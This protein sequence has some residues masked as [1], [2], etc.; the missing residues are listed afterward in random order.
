MTWSRVTWYSLGFNIV[1]R[2][3]YFYYGLKGDGNAHQIFVNA[4][5]LQALADM[6]RNEGPVSFN[7]DGNYFVTN[8][9]KV[10]E[11][12]VKPLRKP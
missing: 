10:G 6:F 11:G 4:T 3:C 9:E 8:Q 7:S 2:E 12:E 1:D 5:E